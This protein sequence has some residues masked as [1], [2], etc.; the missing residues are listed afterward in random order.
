MFLRTDFDGQH[1]SLLSFCLVLP[2]FFQNKMSRGSIYT[3]AI[4]G[5]SLNVGIFLIDHTGNRDF[6]VYVWIGTPMWK[7]SVGFFVNTISVFLFVCFCWRWAKLYLFDPTLR[8]VPVGDNTEGK[9]HLALNVCVCVRKW[10][11][12]ASPS[13]FPVPVSGAHMDILWW[14]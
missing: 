14:W 4:K 12:I 1:E 10:Q 3:A 6:I 11:T 9:C 5:E 7:S 2:L 8:V 13:I